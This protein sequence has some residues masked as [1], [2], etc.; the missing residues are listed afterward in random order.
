MGG[1]NPVFDEIV[2]S[3]ERMDDITNIDTDSGNTLVVQATAEL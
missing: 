2:L 3:M 1:S